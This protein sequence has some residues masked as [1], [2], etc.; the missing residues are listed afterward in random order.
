MGGSLTEAAR[1]TP[2]RVP[3]A[4]RFLSGVLVLVLLAAVGLQLV[5]GAL[6]TRNL[7]D[8]G[9]VATP[10]SL[11]TIVAGEGR[12]QLEAAIRDVAAGAW[13]VLDSSSGPE[14]SRSQP[15]ALEFDHVELR[16]LTDAVGVTAAVLP[17][18]ALPD[19][20]RTETIGT[21]AGLVRIVVG[22]G[23]VATLLMRRDATGLMVVDARLVDVTLPAQAFD[24]P[25]HPLAGLLVPV[26][27]P[28]SAS[29][30]V[31]RDV[32]TESA[33]LLL[34]VLIGGLILPREGLRGAM[35]GPVALL[36]GVSLQ[37]LAGLLLL[38]G[39]GTLIVAAGLGLVGAR[40]V[41]NTGA[42][43]GWRVDDRTT[44][45]GMAVAAVA[46]SA[47][48]RSVGLVVVSPDSM[49]YLTQAR[50]LGLGEPVL[51]VLDIK[52]GLALQALHAPAFALGIEGL[53]ALG[54]LLL[55]SSAAILAL[56]PRTLAPLG[57]PMPGARSTATVGVLAALLLLSSDWMR[58]LAVYVN[59]HVLVG[60]MLL[61]IAL[62]WMIDRP[63][64]LRAPMMV[65][66][67]GALGTVV[68]ARAEAVLIVGL[69][70]SA[71]LG[72][73][74]F[75]WDWAW[76]AT[77]A[78]LLVWNGLL[79]LG[80]SVGG[81]TPSIP[82]LAGAAA[83]AALLLAGPFLTRASLSTRRVV[84]SG[85]LVG[86]WVAT[87]GL[88]LATVSGRLD[89]TFFAVQVE[90]VLRGAGRWGVSGS[91]LILVLAT[92]ALLTRADDRERPG[93][94]LVIGAIPITLLAKLADGTD[95]IGSAEAGRL[96]DV[97]LSGGGR[98]G[99]ADSG[100]RMF[101]HFVPV[102]LLLLVAAAAHGVLRA[103]GPSR[104]RRRDVLFGT[105]ATAVAL[106]MLVTLWTPAHAGPPGPSVTVAALSVPTSEAALALPD[107]VQLTQRVALPEGDPL[108]DDVVLLQVCATVVLA[109]PQGRGSAGGSVLLTVTLTDDTGRSDTGSRDLAASSIGPR[110]EETVCTSLD[111]AAA[112]PDRATVQVSGIGIRPEA[113]VTVLA[114]EP[115][116]DGPGDPSARPFV[117]GLSVEV[118]A[119]SSDP[120]GRTAR[121]VSTALR[122]GLRW[123]PAV[124]V[125]AIAS[126]VLVGRQQGRGRRGRDGAG[127]A[128][129]V[130]P[131][132]TTP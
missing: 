80:A 126:A 102:T 37:V 131:G 81:R 123:G 74:R 73:S 18:F 28:S 55:G 93:W 38:P 27:D 46:A 111:P 32:A 125:L 103:S 10:I 39:V 71:T 72:G 117:A 95:R 62:M 99:W 20:S 119:P 121:A 101:S 42:G 97:L 66:V 26:R 11:G 36:A 104:R 5:D 35:R 79:L 23:P 63:P 1:G 52:R 84:S 56:L 50:A 65:V 77:G 45:A 34:L 43:T 24:R 132:A 114:V 59:S 118:D 51:A 13:I 86:L 92:A 4:S 82:V 57:T 53:L 60:A 85:A 48:V 89:I 47:L 76:P 96:F 122:A 3:D 54:V 44:L 130:G 19:G 17:R 16:H 2:A 100:N 7:Q 40:V 6:F 9:R 78:L 67:V 128:G 110:S 22:D 90:N 88:L 25:Q 29:R 115:D 120:R 127:Q 75:R 69:V 113:S 12:Y 30:T 14:S 41:R 31:I 106:A 116:D 91:V 124:G 87:G 94:H 83:G 112:L 49:T 21:T 107:G 15:P 98:V 61:L 105:M 109:A 64:A 108:P 8:R 70:A 33:L 129:P 68:L 58:F